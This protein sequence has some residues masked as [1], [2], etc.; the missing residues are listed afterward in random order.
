MST[1][2][3][4]EASPNRRLPQ[5]PW[6]RIT[7]YRKLAGEHSGGL[8]DLSIG[9]PVD[10][11][12]QAI[13]RA[14]SQASARP[15]YPN[16]A[17]SPE[18]QAAMRHWLDRHTQVPEHVGV[19]PTIGSKELVANLPWQLG[20]GAGDVVAIPHLAYPTYEVGGLLAK[21]TVVAASDPRDVEGVSLAWINYP[22]NPT[23]EIASVDY[24]RDL[25][26]WA[27]ANDVIL[28]SDECYYQ[29]WFDANDWPTSVLD[30][31]VNDG[32][33]TGLIAAHS[34]SKRSNL[35]GYRAGFIA[36]DPHIID[37]LWQLRRHGGF[38]VPW[39]VQQAMIACLRDEEHATEQR[40]RYG[41][42]R[43]V[44]TEAVQAA[45]FRIEHSKAGLYLWATRDE[46]CWDTMQYLAQLGIL[47]GPGEFYG[48]A[49]ANHVRIGLTATDER[50]AAAADRL[51]TGP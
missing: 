8:V 15:G 10:E 34:L 32:D 14:L 50:I 2:R 12:P 37:Q 30:P 39:P 49:G 47:A 7:S 44:L 23:G 46:S 11:V 5:F 29:V 17:G 35:A 26:A 19:L 27:R 33:L 22:A 28:V 31:R 25:V 18:L 9:T 43:E 45:G 24:L 36:G 13:Q 4:T 48:Q 41:R 38:I 3:F 21:A 42:R 51:R 20:L 16:V 40:L 1:R 6:D